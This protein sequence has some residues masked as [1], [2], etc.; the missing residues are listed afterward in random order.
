MKRK[1]CNVREGRIVEAC[2]TLEEATEPGIPS[3]RGKGIVCWPLT[4]LDTGKPS[5]TF[6]GAQSG[7]HAPRGIVF[8]FCP[9][10]GTRIDAPVAT[11]APQDHKQ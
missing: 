10:C 6:Y 11:P 4:N 5:R 3:K 8:N 7:K 1:T 9:F 2:D